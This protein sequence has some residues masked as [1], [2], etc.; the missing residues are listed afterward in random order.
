M[1][2]KNLTRAPTNTYKK[3][4]RKNKIEEEEEDKIVQEM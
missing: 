4:K 2:P 1:D 3:I